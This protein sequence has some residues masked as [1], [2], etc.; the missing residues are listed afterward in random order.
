M[1]TIEEEITALG[2]EPFY[3]SIYLHSIEENQSLP[4]LKELNSQGEYVKYVTQ[5]NLIFDY[6][7]QQ[8]IIE[9]GNSINYDNLKLLN[10]RI[11]L[12]YRLKQDLEK[13]IDIF[14]SSGGLESC[15]HEDEDDFGDSG[16]GI[17]DCRD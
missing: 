1:T 16:G 2:I 5:T 13:D 10:Q 17:V 14:E 12:E 6:L 11:S 15:R 3:F 8:K 4:N 7:Q 9:N